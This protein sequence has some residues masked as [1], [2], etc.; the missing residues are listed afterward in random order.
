MATKLIIHGIALQYFRSYGPGWGVVP[1]GG[2]GPVAVVGK[3]GDGKSTSVPMALTW[4]YF[5]KCPPEGDGG[6]R[7]HLSGGRL[8][9]DQAP[10]D[11]R[12][13]VV[14]F[15]VE[16]PDAAEALAVVRSR[17]RT[18]VEVVQVRRGPTPTWPLA[19]DWDPD[20]WGELVGTGDAEVALVV[21][22]DFDRFTQ[23]VVHGQ[24]DPWSLA[25]ATDKGKRDFVSALVQEGDLDEAHMK[26]SRRLGELSKERGGVDARLEGDRRALADLRIDDLQTMAGTWDAE[27]ATRRAD[28]AAAL[29]RAEAALAE[30][31]RRDVADQKIVAQR[32]AIEAQ[33]PDV[34]SPKEYEDAA[35]AWRDE[36]SRLDA[37]RQEKLRA[38]GE[39]LRLKIGQ[40]CPTCGEV[41][42]SGGVLS[43]RQTTA[44]RESEVAQRRMD[45]ARQGYT[46]A[47]EAL[48]AYRAYARE[49]L[50]AWDAELARVPAVAG[51]S[52]V[53]AVTR[54]V[55]AQR[56]RVMELD[57]G[58][59][60]HQALLADALGRRVGLAR[61]VAQGAAY[62]RI[63]Q[64]E[65]RK[66]ALWEKLLSPKGKVR[67]ARLGEVLDALE[68]AAAP[69]VER[70][71]AGAMRMAIKR[72][73][74]TGTPKIGVVVTLIAPD[75]TERERDLE[76]LSGGQ[77]R[78]VCFAL[79][80]AADGAFGDA[81]GARVSILVL[82]EAIFS[83]LDEPGKAALADCLAGMGFADVVVMDHDPRL[84]ASGAFRRVIRV[85]QDDAGLSRIAVE[86]R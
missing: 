67:D 62:A 74:K 84:S 24:G 28:A 36:V 33:R 58:D 61:R 14:V 79:D 82:D 26:V 65:E 55:E 4:A 19:D 11:G 7:R 68:A 9:C 48:Q 1:L 71:S 13:R 57:R 31:Q 40:S 5:G 56:A 35:L 83:G 39:L 22:A 23:T 15:H 30:A 70:M 59:N 73:G 72:E 63:L 75:G 77:R 38:A 10:A 17:G 37:V 51:S 53:P 2:R 16:S 27:L 20:A 46:L 60:P 42:R 76:D 29:E 8:V 54:E 32:R 3:N 18:G 50:A 6:G 81:V 41:V 52:E 80:R 25:M 45:E 78:R 64:E 12:A 69:V 66:A 85:S 86:E 34:G 44:T 21:G 49:A 43:V 47:D